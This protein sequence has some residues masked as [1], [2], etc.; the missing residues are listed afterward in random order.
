MDIMEKGKEKCKI[1]KNIRS[2]IAEKYGLDYTAPECNHQG[3]CP[4]TCPQCDAELADI[5]R[6]L[7]EKGITDISQD[8]TLS[9]MV[10][11]YVA[12]ADSERVINRTLG[13]IAP[14]EDFHIDGYIIAPEEDI[15]Q[16]EERPQFQRKAILECAV[17][18]IGFHDIN[19][20]WD[21]LS[22]GDK[23]ALVRERK[24]KYDKNAVAVACTGD[25]DGNPDDFDFDF[26]LGY[27]PRTENHAIAAMLDMGW[28][29]LIE[30]EISEK[31]DHAPYN[32]RLHIT[33]YIRSKE[34]V[35]PKDD[36]LRIMYFNNDGEWKN[37]TDMLWEKGHSYFRWGGFPPWEHDLPEKGDKVVFMHKTGQETEMYLMMLIAID[38]DCAPFVEDIEELHLVDDCASYVLTAVKGPMTINTDELT[39]LKGCPTDKW[40]HD[41]K[42]EKEVSDALMKI[43]QN[44]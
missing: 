19:D 6:Q 21:E 22:V 33:V 28:E 34:P 38:D 7:K 13:F 20:I 16:Q 32:D 2:Y 36:R 5:Q 3:D 10:N 31:K 29:D 40:Q 17:A 8:E 27:I 24:N 30:A 12:A 25:Y 41:F 14:K 26:I 11:N 15:A 43:I 23:L 9:N 1:L 4:G 42:L 44:N 18:G 39:F 35:K 37:F